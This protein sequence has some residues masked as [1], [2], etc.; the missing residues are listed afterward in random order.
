MSKKKIGILISG[1]GSNMVSIAEA[2]NS[3]KIP[4]EISIVI[5]NRAEA[6]GLEKAKKRGIKTTVISHKDFS[7]R[8]EFDREIARA[9]EEKSVDLVCLAGFMRLLSSRFVAKFENRIMNIHPSLLPAFTGLDA[10]KQAFEW[11]VKV[12]GCTV[13]FIDDLLDHGPII[14]QQPVEVRPDD[15]VDTLTARILEVEHRIYPKA[16]EL[17]CKDKLRIEGRRVIIE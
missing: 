16:V 6:P 11:G 17:F 5:S 10:Q 2:V 1:R 12:T 13:H 4:A 3:G 8:E 14:I 9:L 15:T 7:S